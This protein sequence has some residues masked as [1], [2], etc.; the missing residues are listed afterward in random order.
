MYAFGATL[1]YLISFVSLI[2]LRFHDPY[3][4]RPYRFPGN[5]RWRGRDVPV[6]GFVGVL[7]TGAMLA[8]VVLTHPLGRIAGPAWVLAAILYY[9][10]Y[11]RTAGKPMLRSLPR[12]WERAQKQILEE[13][14]E[15]DL[16]EQYRVALAHRDHDRRSGRQ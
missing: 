9:W 16:L 15:F 12:D 4:P 2:V 6:L 13:A 14:E 3:S 8:V 7:C 11:R 5:I 1:A 10:W